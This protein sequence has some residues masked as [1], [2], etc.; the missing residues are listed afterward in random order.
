M[1]TYHAK[2]KKDAEKLGTLFLVAGL[3]I[4][5]IVAILEFAQQIGQSG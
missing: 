2:S 4:V 3:L 1:R 5:T